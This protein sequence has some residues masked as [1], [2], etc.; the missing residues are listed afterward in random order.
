[1]SRWF[2]KGNARRF[3]RINMPLRVFLMP[4]SP[5]RD[6]DIYATGTDYFPPSIMQRIQIERK[7]TLSWV[8]H[9]QEHQV[10]LSK[11]ISEIIEF[12]EFF[13]HCTELL[14]NGK[15][16]QN[17]TTYW[18]TLTQY[19]NGFQSIEPLRTS[20][21]K[22]YHYFKSIEEKYLIFL[23]SLINIIEKSTPNNF[24]ASKD[25]G[26]GYK[27]DEMI[28]TFRNPKFANIPLIQ[29]IKHL[30]DFM[31]IYLS[32]FQQMNNDNYLKQYPEEWP[33]YQANVSAG[34]L[35]VML[36]KRYKQYEK[37]DVYIHFLQQDQVIHFE[38]SVVSIQTL[39]H[40]KKER[41]ALNFEFPD[42]KDQNFLQ[43][44]IEKYEIHECM[45]VKLTPT[46]A[47]S[48]PPL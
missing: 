20:A 29:S 15:S 8:S 1:M 23:N 3:Y 16:P 32:A 7:E 10:I 13:G 2:Q 34:G 44:E 14:S 38:A 39:E 37:L 19:K 4:H 30:Y 41:I 45:D 9:I 24:V 40:Q 42:G 31:D 26:Y 11:L 22:T 36:D 48:E 17:E 47:L 33:T 25:L 43:S 12:I 5:I 28:N 27:V 18:L 6:R 35:A 46:K 21:P